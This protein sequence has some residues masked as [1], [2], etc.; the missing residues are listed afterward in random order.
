MKKILILGAG[1]A[2]T[3][4]ANHLQHELDKKLWEIEIIDEKVEHHYQ[5]GYLFLPFDIYGP[6]D[7]IKTIE[8]FI[9]KGVSL[10]KGKI[11][12]IDPMANQVKMVDGTSIAYDVLI[13]ATGAKIA[14]EETEGMR[15]SEWQK[16]VFDFYTFEGALALRN[17]LREWDGGNMVVHIT[18]MPIKCPVAPLEFAF[19]ADSFFK[20]KKMREKVKITFV[21]PL[22]GAF[23]KPKATEALDHLLQ[24]KDIHIESD[25]AIESVDNERKMIIDYGGREIP[26]DLLVTVP[27]NK[28]DELMER[29]NMGDDLNYVPTNKATLQSLN[30]NNVFVIG[31]A[32]NV[33]ASKAGSVAHFEAEILTENIL[34]FIKNEP[35]KEDFDGHA[36]CFIETGGGKALLIDFNYTHEPVEG[37]FPFPGVGP[38]RLLKES[39]M[40]HM[41]KLAFRWIYWNMLLKGTHIPFVSA[42]MQEAGKQ[43]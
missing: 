1:T 35:L 22:S 23:T 6:E 9:P 16:S 25:F 40:N 15:G 33:P 14:P 29:S 5:P 39:R 13:I 17:K 28:G 21:T 4:M 31:D 12:K 26:F 10:R 32:S 19:L 43:Y 3:M 37:T 42:Q 2:G 36:N 38:L 18:E 11:D 20:N 8:E 34:R 41:G 30:Y 27:T 7:I 24:E